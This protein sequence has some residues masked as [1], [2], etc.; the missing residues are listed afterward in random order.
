MVLLQIGGKGK[1]AAPES[2]TR[3]A[4]A[5]LRCFTD[6]SLGLGFGKEGLE[7]EGAGDAE[8]VWVNAGH[9]LG[10]VNHRIREFLLGNLPGSTPS[11]RT[12]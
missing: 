4:S 7:K 12:V 8:V 3:Q 10:L 11:P 6:G 5:V 9:Q 1:R 2:A